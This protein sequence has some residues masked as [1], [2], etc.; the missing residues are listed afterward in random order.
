[1]V[2]R[3]AGR[4]INRG[5]GMGSVQPGD[6]VTVGGLPVTI[7]SD[8]KCEAADMVLCVDATVP[9][10]FADNLVGP[11][12][13]CGRALQWRPHAPKTP[14]RVCMGCAWL[15]AELTAGSA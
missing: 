12:H 1:M 6:S 5:V 3:G 11:C 14:P 10:I 13:H 2:R 4:F 15:W 9:L 8:A 7:A